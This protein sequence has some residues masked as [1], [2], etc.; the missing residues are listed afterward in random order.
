MFL[1]L[2]NGFNKTEGKDKILNW[3][4]VQFEAL[5]L[6][7]QI[8]STYIFQ[9]NSKHLYF[10]KY[11][12]VT[13]LQFEA[14]VT[15]GLFRLLFLLNKQLKIHQCSM[16]NNNRL[17]NYIFALYFYYFYCSAFIL[18]LFCFVLFIPFNIWT[19]NWYWIVLY[20]DFINNLVE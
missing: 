19:L 11:H 9:S 18:L 2:N 14:Q 20:F 3:W 13:S 15:T 5:I 7:S 16:V 10:S 12:T 1:K 17:F 6:F 8:P 4:T